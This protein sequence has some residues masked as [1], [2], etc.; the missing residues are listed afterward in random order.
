MTS[1]N[2]L[3]C[4]EVILSNF[5]KYVGDVFKFCGRLKL[6]ELWKYL[7][8]ILLSYMELLSTEKVCCP[9]RMFEAK[10]LLGFCQEIIYQFL[11]S[12]FRWQIMARHFQLRIQHRPDSDFLL[13]CWLD[14]SNFRISHSLVNLN[15]IR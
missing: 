11:T 15:Q 12:L 8:D 3:L 14:K 9:I 13:F 2:I 6:N 7:K 5:K 4:F 10:V 1:P